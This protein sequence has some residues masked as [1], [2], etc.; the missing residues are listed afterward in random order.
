MGLSEQI[1]L[2]CWLGLL[3]IR[4][5]SLLKIFSYNP[6]IF[7]T[8]FEALQRITLTLTNPLFLWKRLVL[9]RGCLR[10]SDPIWSG[11]FA[12]SSSEVFTTRSGYESS[13]VL[14]R[15]PVFVLKD[16]FLTTFVKKT[17]DGTGSGLFIEVGA[18]FGEESDR[19]CHTVVFGLQQ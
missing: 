11:R 17:K 8:G 10:V 19:V 2:A 12:G 4:R 9:T 15:S 5:F 16:C 6:L 18:G 7:L 1:R 14:F 3:R 13:S